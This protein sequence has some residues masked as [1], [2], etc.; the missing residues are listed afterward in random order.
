[1][2]AEKSDRTFKAYNHQ[3]IHSVLEVRKF[4]WGKLLE[5]QQ[6]TQKTRSLQISNFWL[7]SDIFRVETSPLRA[8]QTRVGISVCRETN[9]GVLDLRVGHRRRH[10]LEGCHESSGVA[11]HLSGDLDLTG[12]HHCRLSARLL[13]LSF[14][15]GQICD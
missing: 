11:L 10:Q 9:L 6:L 14:F 2:D 5:L 8:K 12:S 15:S 3:F 7:T 1:M 13:R 4:T